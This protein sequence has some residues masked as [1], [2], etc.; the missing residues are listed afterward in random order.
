MI[1]V[2]RVY[3]TV[4]SILNTNIRGNVDPATIRLHIN[5]AVNEI[6]ENLFTEINIAFNRQ[7]RG[8]VNIGSLNVSKNI[9]SKINYYQEEIEDVE[10]IDGSCELPDDLKLLDTVFYTTTDEEDVELEILNRR[11]EFNLVKT[12]CSMSFPICFHS[13]KLLK[14]APS[15]IG[16][17]NIGYLRKHKV[18]N[19][20]YEVINGAEIFN[21]S[22]PNFQDIDIHPSEESNVILTT[23]KYC[24]LNLKEQDIQ[25]FVSRSENMEL[26]NKL[27]N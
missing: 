26:N 24:G 21:P 4:R 19:W 11:S 23:L 9:L 10:I 1:S 18:A 2:D 14:I 20:T 8:L 16:M 5:K 7:N 22:H 12:Q 25:A 6:N 17:V 13:G 15:Q 27:S 3:Q